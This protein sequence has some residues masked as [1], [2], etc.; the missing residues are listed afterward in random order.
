[1]RGRGGLALP[2]G[3]CAKWFSAHYAQTIGV[4]SANDSGQLW[5]EFSLRIARDER[6]DKGR[7]PPETNNSA[8]GEVAVIKASRLRIFAP[9]G[10]T[11]W[12]SAH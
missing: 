10:H 4:I 7:F 6:R 8:L 5:R 11:C 9:A 1:M 12:P 3:G 2:G